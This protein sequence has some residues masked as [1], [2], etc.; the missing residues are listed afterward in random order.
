M[1]EDLGYGKH[2]VSGRGSGNTRNGT[3]TKTVM[4]ET[5]PVEIDVPRDTGSSFDPQIIRKP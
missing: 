1:D 4:T 3:R 2:D 5:G